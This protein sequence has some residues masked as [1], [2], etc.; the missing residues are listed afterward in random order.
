MTVEKS[1]QIGLQMRRDT[2]GEPSLAKRRTSFSIDEEEHPKTTAERKQ[3]IAMEFDARKNNSVIEETVPELAIETPTVESDKRLEAKETPWA[4]TTKGEQKVTGNAT[5]TSGNEALKSHTNGSSKAVTT[6]PVE[7]KTTRPAPIT[8]AKATTTSKVS[9][10]KSPLPKTPT[11]PRGRGRPS[12]VTKK[13]P[14]KKP[15]KISRGSLGSNQTSKPT[16]RSATTSGVA[17][18]TR[19]QPS[20]PQTGFVKPKPR[21][22]TRPVKLPASLMAH[23]ASSGSKT[24]TAPATSG[25]QSLSRASGNIQPT[26]SL[27]AHHAL[28]RSPSRVSTTTSTLNRKTSTLN[29]GSS[30]PSLGPPPSTLRKQSSRQSLPHST[31]PADEGFLAR[32]MRPTTSSASKTLEKHPDTPPKRTQ[33]VRRPA[34]SDGHARTHEAPKRTSVAPKAKATTHV[35][36]PAAKD[37]KPTPLVTKDETPEETNVLVVDPPE[38]P[39]LDI[40]EVSEPLEPTTVEIVSTQ[41]DKSEKTDVQDEKETNDIS[42]KSENEPEEKSVATAI[43]EEKPTLEE[44]V[45]EHDSDVIQES[46]EPESKPE[47]A[48]EAATTIL[49]HPSP[50]DDARPAVQEADEA[51]PTIV[52]EQE[53]AGKESEVE[54]AE[55][56]VV[57]KEQEAPKKESEVE[58]AE[59]DTIVQKEVQVPTM[60]TVPVLQPLSEKVVED[61]PETIETKPAVVEDPEDVKAREEI[62]RLNAEVLKATETEPT[63]A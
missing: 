30:R 6:R 17:P 51:E 9:P 37:L 54:E 49:E 21:S 55:P 50:V 60:A 31:A 48:K 16:S 24:A 20:P 42:T 58:E 3:S 4:G 18:K 38:P 41:S 59:N 29:K 36:K 34:T 5:G 33:S 26:N 2:S 1:G 57:E 44:S 47:P 46:V 28:S 32:M 52:E 63:N 12:E 61:S 14:D 13:E 8:T 43:P 56:T 11:T 25:R 7:K 40:H 10:T 15:E 45:V 19:I 23:T 22:P 53:A 35:P 39:K 62:A 27:Q